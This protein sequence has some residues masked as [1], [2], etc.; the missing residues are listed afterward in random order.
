MRWN[1]IF[2]EI[3]EIRNMHHWLRGVRTPLPPSETPLVLEEAAWFI[4]FEPLGLRISDMRRLPALGWQMTAWPRLV[5]DGRGH[6]TV[7]TP[8][9]CPLLRE[10]NYPTAV[11]KYRP[12]TFRNIWDSTFPFIWK[13]ITPSVVTYARVICEEIPSE[14]FLDPQQKWRTIPANF[15]L[16]NKRVQLCTHSGTISYS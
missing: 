13:P 8:R 16:V 3:G 12:R 7:K 4:P 1:Y 10:R 14:T 5:T 6:A 2:G 9:D 15:L 11:G